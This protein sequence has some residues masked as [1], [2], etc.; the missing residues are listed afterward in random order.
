[1][2]EIG[3]RML[4]GS[5]R[6]EPRFALRQLRKARGFTVTVVLTLALGIGATTAIFSLV[7]GTLLCPLPFS[8]PDRLVL[9]G[10]HIGGGTSLPLR[11]ERLEHIQTYPA[12]YLQWAAS[13]AQALNFPAAPRR[14]KWKPI[15]S[16]PE[17]FPRSAFS[18]SSA[19]SS[20]RRRRTLRL[21][22]PPR[23]AAVKLKMQGDNL[24]SAFSQG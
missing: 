10:D 12:R 24:V 14:K 5:P 21:R 20:P 16:L 1:M 4:H 8:N 18:P 17:C 22:R 23:C 2:R 15:A 13:R 19:A 3:R 6:T 11:R 9:L 7:E